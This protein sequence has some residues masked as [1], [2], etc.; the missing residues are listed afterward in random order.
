MSEN[1]K[2]NSLYLPGVL[3][4]ATGEPDL[5][6]LANLVSDY[7]EKNGMHPV[8]FQPGIYSGNYNI[9]DITI[10]YPHFS[11]HLEIAEK[12]V[13][14]ITGFPSQDGR[15]FVDFQKQALPLLEQKQRS[16][17]RWANKSVLLKILEEIKEAKAKEQPRELD[18]QI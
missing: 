10:S 4:P 17:E 9:Q 8:C 2:L 7:V 6:I 3:S 5:L 14:H 1:S 13:F 16:S 15:G 11:I 12:D 18:F